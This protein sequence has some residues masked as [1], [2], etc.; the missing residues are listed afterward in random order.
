MLLFRL[1]GDGTDR[2]IDRDA[3]KRN[4]QVGGGLAGSQRGAGQTDRSQRRLV[5]P[6][7]VRGHLDGMYHESGNSDTNIENTVTRVLLTA[8]R[9]LSTQQHE[10]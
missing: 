1:Y 6:R 5:G 10:Y 4:M 9:V 7:V 8:I 2:F 3:E